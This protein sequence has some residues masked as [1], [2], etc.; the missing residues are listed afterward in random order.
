GLP[1]F[2]EVLVQAW[3]GPTLKLGALFRSCGWL[4]VVPFGF[5]AYCA[6]LYCRFGDPFVFLHAQAVWG[7]TLTTPWHAVVFAWKN[8]PGAYARLFLATELVAVTTLLIGFRIR[9]RMSYQLYLGAMLLMLVCNSLL[10]SMPR[11]VSVLFPLQITLAAVT[12]RFEGLY[13]ALI[14]GSVALLTLCLALYTGG[15]WL[16]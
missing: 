16:T 4:A 8:Y 11:Y 2:W 15:Y 13:I 5:V 6:Y 10:E 12:V 9:I 7:R 3:N 1:L 14:A